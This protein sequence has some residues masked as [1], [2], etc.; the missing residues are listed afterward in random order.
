MRALRTVRVARTPT[1]VTA[2]YFFFE[3]R[4]PIRFTGWSAGAGFERVVR[5]GWPT[6]RGSPALR[7]TVT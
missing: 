4:N 7:G 3:A 1:T 6:A 2:G 5:G